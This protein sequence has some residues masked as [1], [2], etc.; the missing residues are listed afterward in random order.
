MA[1]WR[2][3][4]GRLFER[5]RGLEGRLEVKKGLKGSESFDDGGGGDCGLKSW[6]VWFL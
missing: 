6:L 1:R 3:V 2:D 5:G 4:R